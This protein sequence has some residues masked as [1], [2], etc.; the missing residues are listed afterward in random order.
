PLVKRLLVASLLSAAVALVGSA[1]VSAASATRNSGFYDHQI[2][3]YVGTAELTS[4]PQAAQLIAKGNIVYH[5]V[6]ASGNTPTVQC[7]RLRAALPK[8]ATSCNVLNFIPTEQGYQGG[9]SGVESAIALA[10]D[11]TALIAPGAAAEVR[12]VGSPPLADLLAKCQAA[13]VTIHV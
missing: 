4:S 7:A 6:D 11:A 13:K 5:V 12:G 1:P 9:A 3:E 2:I 10:G 8:D